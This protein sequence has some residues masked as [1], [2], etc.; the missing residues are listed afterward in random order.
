MSAELSRLVSHAL[1]HEPWLYELELD[2]QGW[3]GLDALV[4]A[5]RTV[6]RPSLTARDVEAMV[7]GASKQRHEIVDGRIRAIYGHSLPGRIAREA[8]TPPDTLFHGT[9][10][11]AVAAILHE[12]LRPMGRQFVHLS[13]SRETAQSVGTRKAGAPVVL[14]IDAAA[15]AAAGGAFYRGNAMVWLADEVAPAFIGRAGDV[16]S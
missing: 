7:A 12:G 3:V 16:R 6:D 5:L 4:D 8:A 10:P 1:R 15:A 9:S 14:V 11:D 2:D 13:P